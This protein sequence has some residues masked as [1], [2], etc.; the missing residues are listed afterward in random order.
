L[1]GVSIDKKP[2]IVDA[3]QSSSSL[4]FKSGG[5]VYVD[6]VMSIPARRQPESG[7]DQRQL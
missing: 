1:D 6:K 7:E 5:S 2:T 4:T 3:G